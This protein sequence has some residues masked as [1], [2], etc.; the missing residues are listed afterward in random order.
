MEKIDARKHSPKTQFEIRKQVVRLRKQGIANKTI[1]EGLGITERTA[2]GIWQKFLREGESAIKLGR[3][4]RRKGEQR[5][6]TDE[7]ESQIKK[8]IT[9]KTPD[10][11]KLSYA[12]WNR[13][14]IQLLMKQQLKLDVPV[15]TI[16]D[17]LKRWGFSFQKP[18][19]QAYEQKPEAVQKWLDEDY[20]VIKEQAK[21]DKAE[22]YWGDETGIQNDAYQAKGFAPIGKTPVVKLNV[23]KSR[24]NMISAISNQGQVRFML[25]EETMSS[26]LLIQFMSRLIK[27]ANRKVYLI[28]DN[29]RTHHSKVVNQWLEKN[30]DKIAV[31]Y[32]PSYSPE[33][34]PDEYLNGNLK[35]EVHSGLPAR[36]LKELKSKTRSFMKTLQRRSYH[37]KNYFKH[38]RIAYAA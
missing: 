38:P 14:A 25:Y 21:Q 4:G 27:D 16:T 22:I 12:L 2:S 37:V 26:E 1:A 7:Q 11:L 3:R 29:L 24:V 15:R 35:R 34:N 23:N 13:E 32:L 20:P 28:L 6:L 36:T 31:F 18:A 33:L 19:K 5:K 8:A 9:D 17:Y 10:Q 30:K